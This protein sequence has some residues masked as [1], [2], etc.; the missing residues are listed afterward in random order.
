MWIVLLQVGRSLYPMC[1]T[2]LLFC[3]S[4]YMCSKGEVVNAYEKRTRRRTCVTHRLLREASSCMKP[5]L[6]TLRL[7]WHYPHSLSNKRYV[8]K[9][10]RLRNQ[11]QTQQL[12]S[13]PVPTRKH[14]NLGHLWS[15]RLSSTESSFTLEDLRSGRKSNSFSLFVDIGVSRE[16]QGGVRPYWSGCILN[17][18]RQEEAEISSRT[19]RREWSLR[20]F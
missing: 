17:H 13:Q 16:R 2:F 20:Y 9:L 11:I 10:S 19:K 12:P 15:L 1:K 7:H 18:G 8:L 3:L 5:L 14:T 6:I 4:H